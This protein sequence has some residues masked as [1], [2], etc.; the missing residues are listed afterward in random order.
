M[1]RSRSQITEAVDRIVAGGVAPCL[2][3]AGFER[4]ALA[5]VRPKGDLHQVLHVQTSLRNTEQRGRFTLNLALASMEI[6]RLWHVERVARGPTDQQAWLFSQRIGALL[7]PPS[8]R[9]WDIEPATDLDRLAA[10]LEQLVRTRVLPYFEIRTLRSCAGL[11]R[12]L[13]TGHPLPGRVVQQ[14]E[15]RALLLHHEG[16]PAE[17]VALLEQIVRRQRGKPWLESYVQRVE[18]L[19]ARLDETTVVDRAPPVRIR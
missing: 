1:A 17:A 12:H 19:A 5:L 10:E 14:E 3:K 11:L 8:D 13:E 6:S 15:L 4:H 18:R 7:D 16:R 9:W 2:L